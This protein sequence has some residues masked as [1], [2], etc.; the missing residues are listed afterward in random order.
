[1]DDLALEETRPMVSST[2]SESSL[3][4]V[5]CAEGPIGGSTGPESSI[6]NSTGANGCDQDL[7]RW[8][9]RLPV[10]LPSALEAFLPVF[11]VF[12][13]GTAVVAPLLD[14]RTACVADLVIDSGG[15]KPSSSAGVDLSM[16]AAAARR[17]TGI[18][19]RFEV[20]NSGAGELEKNEPIV[21]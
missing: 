17:V 14:R 5:E 20:P 10:C 3:V 18:E 13:F 1:M 15:G 9:G 6:G 7:A 2:S 19:D 8:L 11:L 4:T 21:M 12:D 16:L